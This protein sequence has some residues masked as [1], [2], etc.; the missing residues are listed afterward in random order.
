MNDF[1]LLPFLYAAP[2]VA[3]A[4]IEDKALKENTLLL[5]EDFQ[6]DAV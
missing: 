5:E 6:E 2:K 4:V 1:G 3:P